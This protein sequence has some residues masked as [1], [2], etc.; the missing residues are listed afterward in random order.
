MLKAPFREWGPAGERPLE[1]HSM[2]VACEFPA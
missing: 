2:K 1:R